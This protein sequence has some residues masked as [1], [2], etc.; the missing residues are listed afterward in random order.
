MSFADAIG[1]LQGILT[2]IGTEETKKTEKKDDISDTS[3]FASALKEAN[4]ES[5]ITGIE[6]DFSEA[7]NEVADQ[8][9]VNREI[10]RNKN[11]AEEFK[12]RVTDN[13]S[14]ANIP[15]GLKDELTPLYSQL[16]EA[17]NINQREYISAKIKQICAEAEK[18]GIDGK[19]LE[20]MNLDLQLDAIHSS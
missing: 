11:D 19:Y 4:D 9:F 17:T 18:D 8:I 13:L 10:N 16:C 2:S 1:K 5:D 6:I 3:V 14:N 20:T 15:E 7:E 12:A